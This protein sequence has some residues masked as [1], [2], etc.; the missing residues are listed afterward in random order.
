[1][2]YTYYFYYRPFP[3]D[4]QCNSVKQ[5]KINSIVASK[6]C[7]VLTDSSVSKDYTLHVTSKDCNN[8]QKD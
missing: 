1:M 4:C 5:S 7:K 2:D 3:L 6:D 8:Q